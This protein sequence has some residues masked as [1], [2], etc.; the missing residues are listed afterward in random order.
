MTLASI[1]Y[2]TEVAQPGQV[3]E[4]RLQQGLGDGQP[5]SQ[6]VVTMDPT[7]GNQPK[8][9]FDHEPSAPTR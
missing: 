6:L 5:L 3:F 1:L 2:S 7:F 8:E 4:H 9:L